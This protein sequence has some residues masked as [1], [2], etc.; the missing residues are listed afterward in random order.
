MSIFKTE[1]QAILASEAMR[2]FL[3]AQPSIE[4]MQDG[5]LKIYYKEPELS[6]A[7]NN[8]AKM[9]DGAPGPISYDLIQVVQPWAIKKFGGY[10]IG[11]ALIVY[12][13]GKL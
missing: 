6:I 2:K 3:G 11:A 13:M 12:L 10:V 9:M 8:F 1:G 7:R 5:R 4:T